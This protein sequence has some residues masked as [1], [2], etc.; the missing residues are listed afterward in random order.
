MHFHTTANQS[1]LYNK[2]LL[3]YVWNNLYYVLNYLYDIQNLIIS[4]IH[5]T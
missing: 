3:D 5:S 4:L 1:K 2:Y